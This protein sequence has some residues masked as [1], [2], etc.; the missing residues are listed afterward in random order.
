MSLEIITSNTGSYIQKIRAIAIVL[1]CVMTGYIQTVNGQTLTPEEQAWINE[2]PVVT[3]TSL[4]NR[5][6][7][8]FVSAGNPSGFSIDYLNLVASKTGLKVEYVSSPV[9]ERLSS[10]LRSREIDISHSLSKGAGREE[11]LNFSEAYLKLPK[12]YYGQAGSAPINEYEDLIDKRIATVSGTSSSGTYKNIYPELDVIE[13]SSAKDAL[14][15]VST[16]EVDIFSG[17]INSS[18]FIIT[19]NFISGLEILGDEFVP[20]MYQTEQF[21]LAARNDWPLLIT[22]LNK[23]MDAVKD[24]E[25]MAISDRWLNDY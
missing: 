25:F 4:T 23:G 20:E 7:L 8:D 18:N 10:Q 9:W 12:V 6:P 17:T 21:H 16:G 1:I 11:F 5:G 2:H 22:I 24:E 3:S 15:A 19:R 14:F 13:Y